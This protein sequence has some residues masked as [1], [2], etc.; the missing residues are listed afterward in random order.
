[1]HPK[2]KFILQSKISDDVK[3][4]TEELIL[5]KKLESFWK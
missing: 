5:G 2:E 3:N 1:M 4:D